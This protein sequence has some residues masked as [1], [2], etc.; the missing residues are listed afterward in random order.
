MLGAPSGVQ[1]LRQ[2][3]RRDAQS[4]GFPLLAARGLTKIYRLGRVEVPALRGVTVAFEAGE[5]VCVHGAAGAGKASFAKVLAGLEV[6]TSGELRYRGVDLTMAGVAGDE[7]RDRYRRTVGHLSS[8]SRLPPG[9][10]VEDCLSLAAEGTPAVPVA[11]LLDL[12]GLRDR[13]RD[14]AEDLSASE[15]RRLLLACAV[16]R[17][18]E[19]IICEEPTGGLDPARCVTVLDAVRAVCRVLGVLTIVVTS[20]PAVAQVAPRVLRLAGGRVV[21]DL[22]NPRRRL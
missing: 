2:S 19:L 6:P 15:Q 22:R 4:A 21:A 7:S 13:E 3:V 11:R 14:L 10:T 16:A 12:V 5:L 18:P 9:L 20:D 1:P 17:R 8:L